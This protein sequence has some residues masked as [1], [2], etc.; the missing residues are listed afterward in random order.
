MNN[1]QKHNLRIYGIVVVVMLVSIL[2]T[3]FY[4]FLLWVPLS[5]MLIYIVHSDKK[6]YLKRICSLTH[7]KYIWLFLLFS[8]VI[9]LYLLWYHNHDFFALLA[10]LPVLPVFTYFAIQAFSEE[11]IF[12]CYMTEETQGSLLM[13]NIVSSTL[14]SL[15]HFLSMFDV[16]GFSLII[17]I[18]IRFTLSFLLSLCYQ[19]H[20]AI[21]EVVLLHLFFNFLS[22]ILGIQIENGHLISLLMLIQVSIYTIYIYKEDI[23][24]YIHHLRTL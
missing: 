24:L 20:H 6:T 18:S 9:S 19:K 17:A 12:R 8:T 10:T 13:R 3:Y 11:A 5:F 14:F 4:K 7:K 2:F 15:L 1:L 21:V 16:S 22:D 23:Q